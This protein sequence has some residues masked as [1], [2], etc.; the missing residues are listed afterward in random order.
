MRIPIRINI[1]S[2]Q[3]LNGE[4]KVVRAVLFMTRVAQVTDAQVRL[5][6]L[7]MTLDHSLHAQWYRTL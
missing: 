6:A 4:V 3:L 7:G 2:R 1:D 5:L